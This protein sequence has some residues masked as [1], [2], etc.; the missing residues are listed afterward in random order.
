MCIVLLLGK[1]LS[2]DFVQMCGIILAM[3]QV[4]IF[5][6]FILFSACQRAPDIAPSAQPSSAKAPA[7]LGST[8]TNA[9]FQKKLEELNAKKLP[10]GAS[11]EME[12]A[13]LYFSERR[14][15]EASEIL[16]QLLDK[17]PLYPGA[18][19]LLARC[20]YFLGNPDRAILELEYILTHQEK[21]PDEVIDALFLLGA[22]VLESQT[23]S[24]VQ[25][26]KAEKAWKLYLKLAPNSPHKSKIE[27]GLTVL[28]SRLNPQL[29]PTKANVGI[30]KTP[31][32]DAIAAFNR[33][34]ILIA[35][36]KLKEALKIYP[37][38]AELMTYLGRVFVQTTRPKEALVLLLEAVTKNP[39]HMPSRHYLGMA[40][41]MNGEP[42]KAVD[43]WEE[44][45]KQDPAYARQFRLEER[46]AI[47]KHMLQTV[48]TRK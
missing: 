30:A 15:I 3:K 16:S 2:I 24:K 18:R 26:Q 23:Y 29:M 41:M 13:K 8:T 20:F 14:L 34:E 36:K 17:N 33:G 47:A 6:F 11:S 43:A 46:I 9:E 21:N 19:N 27:E 35:E 10:K 22:S 7:P 25:I 38:D 39:K 1:S 48:T 31:R 32:E 5:V 4:I 12:Y 42:Q 45:Q 44:V 28:S 40:Y 37:A